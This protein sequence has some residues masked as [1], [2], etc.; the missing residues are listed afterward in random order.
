[1]KN[2]EKTEKLYDN[3]LFIC[4]FEQKKSSSINLTI[5]SDMKDCVQ[6]RKSSS[7]LILFIFCSRISEFTYKKMFLISNNNVSVSCF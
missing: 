2:I 4:C 1:M 7:I 3:L 6:H 5:C